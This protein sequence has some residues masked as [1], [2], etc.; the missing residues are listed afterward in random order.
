MASIWDNVVASA[1]KAATQAGEATQVAATKAKLHADLLVID[2]D[3]H[4]RKEKF[5]VEMYAH[6]ESITSTQEF[7]TAD[8][9]LINV[10]RPTLI[11]TQREVAAYERKRD[12]KKGKVNKAEA[13]RSSTGS[14]FTAA[15]IGEK[16]MNA[17]KYAAA[18]AKEAASKTELAM[19]ERQILGFKEEFGVELY[20]IFESMED[21][22]GWLPTDRKVRSL[23]DGAREDIAKMN[24]AKDEKR[25]KIKQL[26]GVEGSGLNPPTVTAAQNV[27]AWTPTVVA[28]PVPPVSNNHQPTSVSGSGQM[29]WASTAPTTSQPVTNGYGSTQTPPGQTSSFGSM[30][31]TKQPPQQHQQQ[32]PSDSGFGFMQSQPTDAM[33][34][35][36]AMP[37]YSN[38]PA[39][40]QP[41]PAQQPQ[42]NFGTVFDPFDG[43]GRSNSALVNP[44][45]SF[46]TSYNATPA[47]QPSNNAYDPFSGSTNQSGENKA[48]SDAD[49]NLFKF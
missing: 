36:S 27:P 4:S 47:A 38:N 29:P 25:E 34:H 21:N 3:M 15:T 33:Q 16:F 19:L 13:N 14:I 26:D 5:G 48:L 18:G 8:D 20:P 28:T 49:M 1:S 2:R 42:Q 40:Q 45:A 9:R 37:Q 32:P 46:G 17:A 6:L 30:D 31:R 22:E 12:T 10:I 44:T 23:Y 39:Q 11:K 24:K 35:T 43:V 41:P 7:Y